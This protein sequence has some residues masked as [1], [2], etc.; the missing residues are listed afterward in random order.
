MKEAGSRRR[1]RRVEEGGDPLEVV[2]IFMSA[3]QEMCVCVCVW[4]GIKYLFLL[5][6]CVCVV[7]PFHLS[8]FFSS[9]QAD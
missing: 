1:R 8:F 2:S 7:S 5:C 6:L 4:V 9:I 3:Q